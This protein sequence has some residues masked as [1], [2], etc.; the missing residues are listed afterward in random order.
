MMDEKKK[1]KKIQEFLF[2]VDVFFYFLSF[3]LHDQLYFTCLCLVCVRHHFFYAFSKVI[4]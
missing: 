3:S 4:Y 1:K 2:K